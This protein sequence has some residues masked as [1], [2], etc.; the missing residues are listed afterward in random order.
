[1]AKSNRDINWTKLKRNITN[2]Q[3]D[4]ATLKKLNGELDDLMVSLYKVFQTKNSLSFYKNYAKHIDKNYE[5]IKAF[6]NYNTA[7]KNARIISQ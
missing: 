2:V 6:T 1:M 3:E 4:V 5:W 7:I